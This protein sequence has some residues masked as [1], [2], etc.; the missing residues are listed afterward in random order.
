M[1]SKIYIYLWRNV[2]IGYINKKWSIYNIKYSQDF[3]WKI[4][5]DVENS[6]QTVGYRFEYKIGVE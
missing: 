3:F 1:L 4:I 6:F 5:N 2:N